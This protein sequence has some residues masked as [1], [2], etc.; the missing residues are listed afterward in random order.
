[1]NDPIAKTP[2]LTTFSGSLRSNAQWL[3]DLQARDKRQ[4]EALGDL[5]H[6]L[7]RNLTWYLFVCR[8]DL[9]RF[10]ERELKQ[11]AEDYS[12]DTLL[13]VFQKLHT[14]QGRSSFLTWANRISI[15]L[16]NKRLRR[17]HWKEIPLDSTKRDGEEV[18]LLDSVKALDDSD[19]ERSLE[20]WEI[21]ETL[22][23]I[24][25]RELTPRQRLVLI[26]R[27]FYGLPTHVIAER[28]NIS[29]NNTHKIMHDARKKLR[30]CLLRAD[31][32]PG[33]ILTVFGKDR[34]PSAR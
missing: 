34:P 31:T 26:Y 12:Q 9:S 8:S 33:Y 2:V 19:P 11:L 13:K 5:S 24:I 17:W 7:V 28:L 16:A 23:R 30:G 3:E 1:M 25:E 22:Q 18:S 15:N 4:D 14:F 21:C 6:Y 27:H 10:A 29:R 32:S 20:K